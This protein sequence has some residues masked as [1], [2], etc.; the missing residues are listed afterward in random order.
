MFGGKK[1]F[2]ITLFDA[3][4]VVNFGNQS[5]T[6]MCWPSLFVWED[7]LQIPSGLPFVV[8]SAWVPFG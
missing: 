5:R 4:Y 1:V 8:T 3:N 2:Y 6:I 7:E